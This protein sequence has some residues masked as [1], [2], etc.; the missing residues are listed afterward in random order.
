MRSLVVVLVFVSFC[1][2]VCKVRHGGVPDPVVWMVA[3]H[4]HRSEAVHFDLL[5]EI[6]DGATDT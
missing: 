6:V 5:K 4:H 2:P 1:L 3:R